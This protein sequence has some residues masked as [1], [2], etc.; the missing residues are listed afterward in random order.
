MDKLQGKILTAKTKGWI[1]ID[2]KMR[3]LTGD[4]DLPSAG[5]QADLLTCEHSNP[6]YF[7]CNVWAAATYMICTWLLLPGQYFDIQHNTVP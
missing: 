5:S 1:D 2:C 4:N 3:R 6:D 7:L